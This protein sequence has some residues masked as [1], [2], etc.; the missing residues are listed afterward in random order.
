VEPVAAVVV[1]L[2]VL[3]MLMVLGWV[4]LLFLAGVCGNSPQRLRKTF[5]CPWRRR[6]VTAD[7]LVPAGAEH[8]ADVIRCTAFPVPERIRCDKGCRELAD[9]GSEVSR[10][11][12]PRWSLIAGGLAMAER[13]GPDG[14]VRRDQP[15]RDADRRRGQDV[16][17]H[18]P[19]SIEELAPVEPCGFYPWRRPPP[20]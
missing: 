9:V 7:F 1:L 3:P 11:L 16:R 5:R 18:T 12:F 4:F 8:P 2:L 10:A 17:T 19:P 14:D 20:P 6:V 15:R 13:S